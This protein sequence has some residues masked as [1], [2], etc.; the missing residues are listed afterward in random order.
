MA[1]FEVGCFNYFSSFKIFDSPRIWIK[2]PT[3]DRCSTDNL[4]PKTKSNLEIKRFTD[5]FI[6]VNHDIYVIWGSMSNKHVQ[7]KGKVLKNLV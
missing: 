6:K 7:D 5:C 3:S 1:V 2:P 4:E